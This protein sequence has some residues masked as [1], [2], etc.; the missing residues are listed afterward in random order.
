MLSNLIAFGF[1]FLH[2]VI[3]QIIKTMKNVL[4]ALMLISLYGC[5]APKPLSVSKHPGQT[6]VSKPSMKEQSD[7]VWYVYYADQ[8]DAYENKVPMPSDEY[9][10]SAKRGYYRARTEYQ[11]KYDNA[12]QKIRVQRTVVLPVIIGAVLLFVAF[13]NGG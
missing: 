12:A 8:I 6:T 4:I 2:L 9:P 5:T 13:S 11:Q 7:D 10:E 3:N 1:L